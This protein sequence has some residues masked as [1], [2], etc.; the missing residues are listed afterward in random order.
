MVNFDHLRRD[1][2]PFGRKPGHEAAVAG[3][4]TRDQ[5]VEGVVVELRA[6]IRV[7]LAGIEIVRDVLRADAQLLGECRREAGESGEAE[8]EGRPCKKSVSWS[9]SE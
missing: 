1:L 6:D 5:R 7:I 2:L 9:C 4:I 3:M 8:R